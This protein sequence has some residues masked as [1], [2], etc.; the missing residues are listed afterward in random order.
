MSVFE[1]KHALIIEDDISAIKVL[2]QLLKQVGVS[3]HVIMDS[4]KVAQ[5]LAEVDVPDVI[6]LDLEMP[7]SNGYSLMSLIQSD[8]RFEGVP[9]VAYTTHLSHL[10]S[11]RDAGFHSFLGKPIDGRN[12]AQHLERILSGEQL[13]I[14]P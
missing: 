9:V 12:F 6:F 1:N 3:A 11:V 8:K 5:E 13:W 7:I 14:V 4:L 10:N 2:G